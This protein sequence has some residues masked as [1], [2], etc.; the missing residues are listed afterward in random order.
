MARYI[1]YSVLKSQLLGGVLLFASAPNLSADQWDIGGDIHQQIVYDSNFLMSRN[2]QAIWAYTIDPRVSV[3]YSTRRYTSNLSGTLSVKRHTDLER[4]DTENPS[5]YWN[6][7]YMLR[8]HEFALDVDYSDRL[9][10]EL[11]AEDTG[12]FSAEDNVKTT[13]VNPYWIYQLSP[14]DTLRM[15]YVYTDRHYVSG[16][17][18]ENTDTTL[19]FDWAR[20][21]FGNMSFLTSASISRYDATSR[22]EK[23]DTEYIQL[24]AGIKK[25]WHRML[26][27]EFRFGYYE[28]ENDQV[29][30]SR[31]EPVKNTIKTS[32]SLLEFV[33][34][35]KQKL[36]TYGFKLSKRL[37]PSSEGQVRDRY[38][39]GAVWSRELSHRSALD[40]EIFW[41]KTEGSDVSDSDNIQSSLS[42]SYSYR[43]TKA[44]SLKAAYAHS[45]QD[46]GQTKVSSDEVSLDVGY[47]F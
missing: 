40:T 11:A 27:L 38:T 8:R 28:T 13:N 23:N 21:L 46:N 34:S 35:H 44:I 29:L 36:N 43:M 16:E 20:Q 45:L 30:F 31:S 14:I 17:F 37:L 47:R 25:T 3:D 10:R 19:A 1:T 12:D 4:Y 2:E 24:A 22:N 26:L 39:A 7:S 18:D 41:G 9:T 15:N 5:Y 6:Q 32:G 33:A 42:L